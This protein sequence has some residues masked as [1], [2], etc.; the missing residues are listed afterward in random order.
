MKI[1]YNGML[2]EVYVKFIN[3]P[4]L[5]ITEDLPV[6]TG[7]KVENMEFNNYDDFAM[8]CKYHNDYRI[9][10]IWDE[11]YNIFLYKRDLLKRKSKV[12]IND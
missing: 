8:Y 6:I 7:G 4:N 11:L 1:E 2:I 9:R 5:F 10:R 12:I 3:N